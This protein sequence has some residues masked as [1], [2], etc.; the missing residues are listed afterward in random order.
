MAS[1]ARIDNPVEL[2]ERIDRGDVV[3]QL[4]PAGRLS[5]PGQHRRGRH[6]ADGRRPAATGRSRSTPDQLPSSL[7]Y[8]AFS[9]TPD[10][11]FKLY[12]KALTIEAEG[13]AILGRI[14]HPGALARGRPG[15]EAGARS[16][17]VVA[18][19]L[20]LFHDSFF[21]GFEIGRRHRRP[22]RAIRAST[23]TTAGASSS[24]RTGDHSINDF[25]FSPDYHVDEIF[26][27]HILGTVTNA[28]YFK[29]Q[30]AYWFD[31][32]RTR[33]IGINGGVIFSMA[34][35]PVST[36]GNSLIYGIETDVERRLPQH[37][38]GLLRR[39]HLG[40]LLAA[41]R[42][43]PPRRHLGPE[44]RQRQRR[45]DPARQPSA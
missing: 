30:A 3:R 41:R 4:R 27:R 32:G 29:P 33:A 24:S 25:H 9:F 45:P 2:R 38:R 19:E 5:E 42:A 15:A 17:W 11:W 18:S 34:Q 31:L 23:S 44:R 1:V 22:G 36:P 14:D 43:R 21:V 26:F 40:R 37:R 35:V 8:G 28:I 13:I 10:V 16:G 20:R 39:R 12:Y 6:A 7:P